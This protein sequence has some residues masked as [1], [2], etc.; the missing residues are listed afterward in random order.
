MG[1]A[2]KLKRRRGDVGRLVV[3]G[4]FH[5]GGVTQAGVVGDGERTRVPGC[6]G[7]AGIVDFEG[8]RLG[9]GPWKGS[10]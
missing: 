5:R 10:C 7:N 8:V 6:G 3:H 4:N 9:V 2:G 1:N